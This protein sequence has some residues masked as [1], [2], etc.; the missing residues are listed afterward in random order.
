MVS[1][2]KHV[3]IGTAGHIDH[4]KTS[5]VKALTGIDCDR[6][7]EERE[8]GI[9]IDL[10]FAYFAPTPELRFGIVDVPGHERFVKN[11]VAGTGGIDLV[12]L[13]IAADEGVM[14]QTREH[15][16]ICQLLGLRR[17]IVVLT[18]VDL[19]DPEWLALVHEE[20]RAFVAGTF[21]EFAPILDFSVVDG[22]GQKEL[23]EAL[24]VAAREVEPRPEGGAPR[25][26]IDRVFSLAGF[27]TV[28]TGTLLSGRIHPGDPLEALPGSVRGRV[29]GLH[30]YGEEILEARSGMRTAVNL[31]GVERAQLGRG[32]VLT[33]PDAMRSSAT[34]DVDLTYLAHARH[35]LGH[36]SRL[37]FHLGTTHAQA[38]VTLLDRAEIAPGETAP[39]RVHLDRDVVSLPGDRFIVRGFEL[40]EQHGSTLGGGVVLDAHATREKRRDPTMLQSLNVLRSGTL[41]EKIE[42]LLRRAGASGLDPAELARRLPYSAKE[43]E[44]GL[45][46]LL[47]RRLALRFDRERGTCVHVEVAQ[48]LGEEM[49]RLVHAYHEEHPER[50]GLPK[51]ELRTRISPGLDPKL[52]HQLLLAARERLIVEQDI[53]REA[54][55]RAALAGPTRAVEE[56]IRGAYRQAGLSPPWPK[57]LA[58]KL[59]LAEADVQRVAQFF[60]ASGELVRVAEDL[61]FER[62]AVEDLQQRLLEHLRRRGE[63]TTQEFK[64]MTGL[65]RKYLIPLQEYFDAIRVTLRVGD[66]RVLR[67]RS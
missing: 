67:T 12:L 66:K 36:R 31:Q 20:V 41:G 16:A 21:L 28:V 15:L 51:E 55:H 35:P 26:P 25:L 4:G 59:G 22:R 33:A 29:R 14:P 1:L 34:L 63:I 5:L 17:G 24:L 10:G 48:A 44:R 46:D 61:Y 6:L 11:M 49:Q 57:E 7:P 18:K 42:T 60:A 53:V 27:G 8:R 56:R 50:P 19:V 54:T 47:S 43:I 13:V 45:A 40:S 38:T 9:T 52:F 37:L 30:A 62:S 23:K 39:V 3:V 32:Q 65:T 2:M 64:E 58:A